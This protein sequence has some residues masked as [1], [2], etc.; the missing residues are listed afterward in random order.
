MQRL[1]W[2]LDL[3]EAQIFAGLLQSEGMDAFVFNEG[4][5]RMAWHRALAFGGYQIWVSAA[6]HARASALLA[7]WRRGE[8][9]LADEPDEALACPRCHA[10]DAQPDQRRR[11]WSF[12]VFH[13]FSVPLPWRWQRRVHCGRCGHRWNWQ[14]SSHPWT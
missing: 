9:A 11:G 10:P 13:L 12:V 2:T 8:L 1:H 7:A 4:I 14:A 5:V 6:D 3:H